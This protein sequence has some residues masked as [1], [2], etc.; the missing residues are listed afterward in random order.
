MKIWALVII[1]VLVIFNS[2][3]VLAESEQVD[4]HIGT[5][6]D[7]TVKGFDP[8]SITCTD[9]NGNGWI[10][11]G[12]CSWGDTS[13]PW[14]ADPASDTQNGNG[15]I[16]GGSGAALGQTATMLIKEPHFKVSYYNSPSAPGTTATSGMTSQPSGSLREQHNE[17]GF[18]VVVDKKTDHLEPYY[19]KFY[20]PYTTV[21]S[22]QDL[23]TGDMATNPDCTGPVGTM[24]C[25]TYS[26][27]I[28]EMDPN[29]PGVFYRY[30]VTGTFTNN[31]TDYSYGC[32][33]TL[34][35]DCTVDQET[36]WRSSWP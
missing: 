27:E 16:A 25:G 21:D 8:A 12:E 29:N 18:E 31:G 13:T 28:T 2:S 15:V 30:T 1:S 10:D 36:D 34:D 5:Y 19:M 14:F 11:Q 32:D 24:S 9:Q 20:I 17:F 35:Q 7:R 22:A 26:K 33:P 3:A 4:R 23:T 6:N